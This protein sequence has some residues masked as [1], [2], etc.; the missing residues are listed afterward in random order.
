MP[1]SMNRFGNT[2]VTSIPLTLA[3]KYGNDN[4][5]A[6][7]NILMCGFGV[8]L[9]WGVVSAKIKTV[10]ILPIIKIDDYFKEGRMVND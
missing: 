1:I 8:G 10:D 4:E 3:D 2:S 5:N 9:A 7:N 6:V